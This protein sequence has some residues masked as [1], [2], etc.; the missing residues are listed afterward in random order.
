M[1]S[2]VEI[3]VILSISCYIQ[4]LPFNWFISCFF[5]FTLLIHILPN[6]NELVY[7]DLFIFLVQLAWWYLQ[8]FKIWDVVCYSPYTYKN[9]IVFKVNFDNQNDIIFYIFS[10]PKLLLKVTSIYLS[11]I[12]Q[13]TINLARSRCLLLRDSWIIFTAQLP[14]FF[15][16]LLSSH[17]RWNAATEIWMLLNVIFNHS[18]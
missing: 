15:S 2:D 8:V 3:N 14:I 18:Q 4:W 11:N 7:N 1:S 9:E 5:I 13:N 17:L 6:K 16:K 12:S 10:L